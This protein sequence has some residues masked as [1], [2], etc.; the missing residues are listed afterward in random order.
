MTDS[1]AALLAVL[2]SQVEFL[3]EDQKDLKKKI[4]RMESDRQRFLIWGII[5]IGSGAASLVGLIFKLI[6]PSSSGGGN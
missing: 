4:D 3:Q 5:V 2:R 1:E 6:L